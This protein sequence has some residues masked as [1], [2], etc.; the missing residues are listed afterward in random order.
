MEVALTFGSLGDIIEL[1]QLSI[2]LGRAIGVGTAAVSGNS[3]K[4][5]QELRHDLDVLV[6]VLMQVVATY[7]QHELGTPL[8]VL[9]SV[10]KS[11][12]DQ[13]TTLIQDALDHLQSRY[14]SNLTKEGSGNKAKDI[15]KKVEWSVREKDR[16][17]ILHEKLQVGMER[18][19]LL[20]TLSAR[21]SARV[22]NATL[23]ARIGEVQNLCQDE[24]KQVLELFEKQ[25]LDYNTQFEKQTEQL[26]A[27]QIELG[28]AQQNGCTLLSM[29]R[30][31]V[32]GILEVKDLLISMSQ[33]VISLQIS[34]TQ[35]QYMRQLDPTRELSVTLEDSLGRQIPIPAEWLDTL[36]WA[37]L[38]SLLVGLFQGKKGQDMVRRQA[39]A[40]EESASGRDISSDRPLSQFLRRGMKIN[41]NALEGVNILCPVPDC[42]MWFRMQ[43]MIVEDAPAP[44]SG[45]KGLE[46]ITVTKDATVVTSIP[47]EPG[48]FLRVRLL[49]V[50]LKVMQ[51]E[52]VELENESDYTGEDVSGEAV[53][54]LGAEDPY[55]ADHDSG[56]EKSSS[57]RRRRHQGIYVNGRRVVLE[58]PGFGERSSEMRGWAGTN[59]GRVMVVPNPPT[60]RT[61]PLNF[62]LT[63]PLRF[64][65]PSVSRE[66]YS[67]P[68]IVDERPRIVEPHGRPRHRDMSDD[69]EER[70]QRRREREEARQLRKETEFRERIE[71]AHVWIAN[72]PAVRVSPVQLGESTVV[73]D[74]EARLDAIKRELDE[75][76]L[77]EHRLRERML[78]ARRASIGP[79]SRRHRVAYGDGMYRWE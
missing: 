14:G 61:P 15:Y 10:T 29:A 64:R 41:M 63:P 47:A 58:H 5:Y 42:G 27:M 46:D 18:L 49:R 40:L 76:A 38:N 59:P 48:D 65:D 75:T 73:E 72:R 8:H 39:Y 24:H 33:A 43:K 36:E 62:A 26:N 37:A 2:K 45:V 4:E 6:S 23:V 77:L 28:T 74:S 12:V 11:V 51:P 3:A 54:D 9:D 35:T 71:R 31:A 57:F 22:D 60:A 78:P 19:N 20:S 34:A 52:T 16:L 53:R 68:Y 67:R 50:P 79:G 21:N 30:D 69:N 17:R 56:R 7:Q 1:V 32:Q 70:A 13:F 25:K 44:E 66:H 55:D